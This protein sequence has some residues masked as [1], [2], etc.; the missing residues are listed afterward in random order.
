M[1]DLLVSAG[2]LKYSKI[3]ELDQRIREFSPKDSTWHKDFDTG[4]ATVLGLIK[5]HLISVHKDCSKI[6]SKWINIGP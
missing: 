5:K 3:V 2:S 1:I 6:A 4:D